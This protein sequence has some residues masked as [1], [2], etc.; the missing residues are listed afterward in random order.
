MERLY[1]LYHALH[2]PKFAKNS[3]NLCTCSRAQ[4]RRHLAHLIQHIFD[5]FHL[6]Q[7]ALELERLH[8]AFK[9]KVPDANTLAFSDQIARCSVHAIYASLAPICKVLFP[10]VM[11]TCSYIEA[12]VLR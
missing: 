7:C 6:L 3:E 1:H 2:I 5:F 4:L 9:V 10:L 12:R 11:C 8:G